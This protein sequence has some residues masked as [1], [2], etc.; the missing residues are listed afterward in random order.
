MHTI[1]FVRNNCWSNLQLAAAVYQVYGLYCSIASIFKCDCAVITK[2]FLFCKPFFEA[3][4]SYCATNSCYIAVDSLLNRHFSQSLP[5]L[6]NDVS[7]HTSTL[8]LCVSSQF[9]YSNDSHSHAHKS[10]LPLNKRRNKNVIQYLQT[11]SKTHS[12]T[13]YI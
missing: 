1:V 10:L 9:S 7:M 13:F 2:T 6:D 5:S 11:M 3:A 8:L 4:V 12:I